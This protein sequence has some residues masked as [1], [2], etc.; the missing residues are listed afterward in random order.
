[1]VHPEQPDPGEADEAY[2]SDVEANG[3]CLQSKPSSWLS[4]AGNVLLF[5]SGDWPERTSCHLQLSRGTGSL[6]PGM[7]WKSM[8]SRHRVLTSCT[9]HTGAITSIAAGKGMILLMLL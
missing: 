1:M 2:Y 5:A 3:G 6:K 9:E 4:K 7:Q 8:T